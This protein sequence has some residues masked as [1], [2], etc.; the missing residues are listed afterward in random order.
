M[1]N[2]L[3]AIALALASLLAVA[4]AHAQSR[5]VTIENSTSDTLTYFYSTHR[6]QSTWGYDH[7]GPSTVV[8][9][10]YSIDINLNDGSGYCIFDFRAEFARGGVLERY[11]VNVCELSTYTYY[12]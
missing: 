7:L 2:H 10:G 6:D 1:R 8:P 9:P 3:V 12:D 11:G 5:W 4:P